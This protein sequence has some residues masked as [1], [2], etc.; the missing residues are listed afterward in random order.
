MK[1]VRMR[2]RYFGFLLAGAVCVGGFWS[3]ARAQDA[4]PT[5][6]PPVT[7]TGSIATLQQ[8]VSLAEAARKARAD[9][10]NDSGTKKVWND[11]NIPRA[12]REVPATTAE[13]GDQAARDAA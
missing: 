5:T 13:G 9:K 6:P 2:N 4:P 1:A 3:P 10:K 8:E 11:D 7:N 12:P